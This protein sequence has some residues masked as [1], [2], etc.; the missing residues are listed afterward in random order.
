MTRG[1]LC[2]ANSAGASS[3]RNS[4]RWTRALDSAGWGRTA[5]M[6]HCHTRHGR[7][8]PE[9]RRTRPRA[10]RDVA[11]GAAPLQLRHAT[12]GGDDL[13]R[14][15]GQVQARPGGLAPVLPVQLGRAAGDRQRFF[16][17][18]VLEGA[19][20]VAEGDLPAARD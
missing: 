1:S 19:V 18:G 11:L 5:A 7:A 15:A 9:G 10:Y 17:G 3:R 6:P 16:A 8:R 20:V 12:E 14:L 13:A 2:T 4:R